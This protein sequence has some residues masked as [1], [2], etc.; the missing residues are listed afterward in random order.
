METIIGIPAAGENGWNPDLGVVNRDDI[1][2]DL[3]EQ[4]GGGGAL[5]ADR[6]MRCRAGCIVFLAG[7]GASIVIALKDRGCMVP[8]ITF[9]ASTV[10]ATA[11]ANNRESLS[12]KPAIRVLLGLGIAVGSVIGACEL[13]DETN[14]TRGLGAE[15]LAMVG[16]ILGTCIAAIPHGSY[17]PCVRAVCLTQR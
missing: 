1:D 17:G 13:L 6:A 4:E 8:A 9:A 14:R 16:I 2:A 10:L 15:A 5:L 12:C 7:T 3:I 11:I